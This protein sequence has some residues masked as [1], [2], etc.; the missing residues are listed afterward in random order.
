MSGD[1]FHRQYHNKL[2]SFSY[3]IRYYVNLSSD[4][5]SCLGS[6]YISQLVNETNSSCIWRN[7]VSPFCVLFSFSIYPRS[8]LRIILLSSVVSTRA[9]RHCYSR[10]F[11]F[12]EVWQEIWHFLSLA[13]FSFYSLCVASG[14]LLLS[15]LLL[16]LPFAHI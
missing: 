7:L 1:K 15:L 16:L 11:K 14:L 10:T 8:F 4:R 5:P 2:R 13:R 3:E 9:L 12:A 6:A